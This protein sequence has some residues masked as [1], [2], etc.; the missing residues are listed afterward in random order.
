[1]VSINKSEIIE[2]RTRLVR[3][4]DQYTRLIPGSERVVQMV[5]DLG[6]I[7]I[8]WDSGSRLGLVPSEDLFEFVD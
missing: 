6:T 3:T 8:A 1:M 7:F 4:S 5:D 2:R